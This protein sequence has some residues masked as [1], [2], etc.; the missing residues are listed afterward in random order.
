VLH[1]L[2]FVEDPTRV[3]RA[4]RFEQRLGFHIAAHTENLI[5]NAVR[6]DFLERLGGK[7]LLAELIHILRE[8]EPRNAVERMASLGLLR[9][10]NPA[11]RYTP[12]IRELLDE[13]RQIIIWFELL[14]LQQPFERWAVY[15]LG[16]CAQLAHEEFM[17]TCIRLAISG[18][19]MRKLTE[20]REKGLAILDEMIQR[21]KR[22]RPLPQS[23]LYRWLREL[24]VETMLHMM[25][26]SNRDE[27]RRQISTYF[28][29]LSTVHPMITGNDLKKLGIPKGPVYR[30]ILDRVLDARLDGSVA[31]RE[32]EIILARKIGGLTPPNEEE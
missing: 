24:P 19:Y 6:M 15:L 10:I 28:T 1:N 5:R 27:I 13:S 26:R 32:D 31:S 14:Y 30:A 21:V 18:T 3:F 23:E 8:K 7:R 22:K 16:L 4:I 25:A 29:H 9:Y 20:S 12:E 2:S 11:L 17:E